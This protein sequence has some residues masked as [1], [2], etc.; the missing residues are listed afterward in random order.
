MAGS[1]N[2]VILIGHL[3]K[4]PET[5]SLQDGTAIVNFQIA[6][7]ETWKDRASGERKEKTE[8]TRVVVMG[9]DHLVKLAGERLRKGSHIYLEGKLQTRKWTDQQ[10][11]DRYTTEVLIGRFDGKLTI[12]D[13]RD[14]GQDDGA[15][16]GAGGGQRQSTGSAG[17][18]RRTAHRGATAHYNTQFGDDDGYL[19]DDTI[20]F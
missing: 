18:G 9:N 15:G 1:V 12:L 3:G 4:D 5:R 16:Y 8:W 13:R 7:S 11:Q 2:K 20:P 10:G 6:T 19:Q 14:D 17:P